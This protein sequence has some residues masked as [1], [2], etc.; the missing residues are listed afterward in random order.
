M[1]GVQAVEEPQRLLGAIAERGGDFW[2]FKLIGPVAAVSDAEP[3]FGDWLRSV[4]FADGKPA[5]SVPAAW[6]ERPGSGMRFATLATPGGLEAT[7]ISLPVRGE[8]DEQ[9]TANFTRWRG[10]VGATDGGEVVDVTLADGSTAT[11][12]AVSSPGDPATAATVEPAP[13]PFDFAVPDGWEAAAPSPMTRL[14]FRTGPGDD[15]ADVTVSRFPPGSMPVAQV[16]GIWRE[17]AKAAEGT[18]D[19]DPLTVAG[20]PAPRIDLPATEPGGAAVFGTAAERAGGLWLFKLA[21]S[22]DAVAAARP[23]FERFLADLQ[24]PETDSPAGATE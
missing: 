24:F 20:G 9:I 18:T 15:A 11:L 22:Q 6:T 3:A 21:G 19:G 17:Q 5:W 16:A 1:T 2:Y 8:V 23:A 14:A 10:Q 4:R 7:V 13:V 12:L